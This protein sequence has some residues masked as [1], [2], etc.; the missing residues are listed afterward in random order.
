MSTQTGIQ[1]NDELR[2]FFG[3]CRE[4]NSRGRYRMIKVIIA[5]EALV[6]EEAKETK[7]SWKDD[8]DGFVL[9]AIDDNEPC[10]MLYRFVFI[11]EISSKCK[12]F[13]SL[14]LYQVNLTILG[15]MKRK[16]RSPCEFDKNS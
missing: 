3:K 5:N 7:G 14:Y 15:L 11:C 10:Y 9:P 8:W 4:G 1:A 13:K 16:T 2:E 6:L 12:Y